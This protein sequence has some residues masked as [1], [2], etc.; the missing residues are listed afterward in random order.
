[1]TTLGRPGAAAL[2]LHCAL[3]ALW[4]GP[5]ARGQDDE[6]GIGVTTVMLDEKAKLPDRW[7]QKRVD[8]MRKLVPKGHKIKV[9]IGGF[10][11]MSKG[12]RKSVR[13]LT[14]IGPDGKPDGEEVFFHQQPWVQGY[15]RTVTW[16]NGVL[17]G[18]EKLYGK[19]DRDESYVRK[20]VPWQ[21]GEVHGVVQS[22]YPDGKLLA[23]APHVNGKPD[24][25]SKSYAPKGFVTRSTPYKAGKRHG[26]MTEHWS[27]TQKRKQVIPY[28]MG[29]V[30]GL[31]R[32]Y[33]DNGK[34]K[35]EVQM[36][37]DR[38]HGTDKRYYEDGRPL[39]AR[40]WIHDEQ[41]SEDE[42]RKKYQ[43]P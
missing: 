26:T 35:R 41:V 18:P 19:T 27:R 39:K 1:M 24:G 13:S 11:D 31:V 29:K 22:F 30:H 9:V 28:K 5:S 21:N 15:T 16:K 40:F 38:F 42:F 6:G 2:A 12:M 33:H 36:W 43:A 10:Y 8:D 3:A 20:I 23:E 25:V 37:E 17:H 7:W 4:P 14:P 32:Q 34:P